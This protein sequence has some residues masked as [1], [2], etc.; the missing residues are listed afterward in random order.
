VWK[1]LAPG[2]FLLGIIGLI[3]VLPIFGGET[4]RG[5][6][7]WLNLGIATIQPSEGIKLFLAM[8][9]A[10]ALA[11]HGTKNWRD[12]KLAG[13]A[14]LACVIL[15]VVQPDLGTTVVI[16]TTA[17]CMMFSA[18]MSMRKLGPILIVGI[19]GA[20]GVIYFTSYMRT[21]VDLWLA[22]DGYQTVNSLLALGS[23]GIFGVGL[24][25]GMQKYGHI[26]ENYTDMIFATIGEE[27]GLVGTGTIILLFALLIWRGFSIASRV[28]D[29][30]ARYLAVGIT[31]MIC[32]QTIINL[33]VVTGLGP[34]TGVTL[35][36]IS[37]GGSSL[38]IKLSTVG[39]LLNISRYAKKAETEKA[40][41]GEAWPGKTGYL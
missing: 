18:G 38:T 27:L 17:L 23:G 32:L 24:G 9:L 37:Y 31:C 20:I 7:R 1:R 4:T 8:F 11:E 12:L 30:Y 22:G 34:V 3:L 21:R 40:V 14:T 25:Q 35:P 6:S 26:P 33:A 15:V 36:F 29:P 13:G 39:I 10:R 5:S 28:K 2:L 41:P 16:A 19:I